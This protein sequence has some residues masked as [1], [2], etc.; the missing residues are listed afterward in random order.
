M[1]KRLPDLDILE[2][3]IDFRPTVSFMNGHC[4]RKG[5]T[6]KL[7]VVRLC[8]V[9]KETA[10]RSRLRYWSNVSGT[11]GNHGVNTTHRALKQSH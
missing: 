2:S 3:K 7:L 5:H 6:R 1:L 8:L 9:R 4:L 10:E 11:A